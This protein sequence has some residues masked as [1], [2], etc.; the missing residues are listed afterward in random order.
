MEK[1]IMDIEKELGTLIEKNKNTE[2]RVDK[3]EKIVDVVYDLAS[4]VKI[5][6]EKMDNANTNITKM[7]SDM[8]EYHQKEPNKIIFN[9]KNAILTGVAGALLGALIML[10]LK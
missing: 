5:L 1:K 7:K 4:N 9:V 8:E 6:A 2:K 10:V 3:L